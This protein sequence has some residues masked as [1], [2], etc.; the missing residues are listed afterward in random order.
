MW[1]MTP[2]LLMRVLTEPSMEEVEEAPGFENEPEGCCCLGYT[3]FPVGPSLSGQSP[4]NTGPL[5]HHRGQGP[6]HIVCL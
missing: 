5:K 3:S 1:G 6:P 2:G 4:S